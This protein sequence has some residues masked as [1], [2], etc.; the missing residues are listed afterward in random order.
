MVEL[1]NRNA[2]GSPNALPGAQQTSGPGAGQESSRGLEQ[3]ARQKVE[4]AREQMHSLAEV[5]KDRLAEQLEQFARALR[6]TGESL[7]DSEQGGEISY[8]TDSVGERL[9]RASRYL[10]DHRAIDLVDGVERFAREKPGL[11]LGGALVAG[12]ALGRFIKSKPEGGM[13]SYEGSFE[14]SSSGYS[15]DRAGFDTYD[16]HEGYAEP[17]E[18]LVGDEVETSGAS[19]TGNANV[20]T[21][22]GKVEIERSVS[23]KE[24]SE[25]PTP[26]SSY[27]YAPSGTFRGPGDGESQS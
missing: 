2:N 1:E 22:T 9:E 14:G 23:V 12:L 4:E 20:A 18:P 8:Y 24:T 6:S 10:R 27:P 26:G 16:V 7:R 11:F 21:G 17:P 5:G 15:V 19:G 3:E 13:E 25:E